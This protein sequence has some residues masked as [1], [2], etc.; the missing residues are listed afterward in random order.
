MLL[1]VGNW[2]AFVLRGLLA[3]AFGLLTFFR[4]GISLLALVYMFG[5]YALAE[6]IFNIIAA[7][8]RTG[9]EQQPW[10]ALLLEGVLSMIA[11]L[12]AFFIPGITAMALLWLIAAWAIATGAMEIA[13]AI[14]LRRQI[15][16][17][18]VLA[19]SGV[20]SILFGA[21]LFAFPGAGALTVV[22]WIGAYAV[23]FG[24]LLIAL[25]IRLRQW[26][27]STF[28]HVAPGFPPRVAPGH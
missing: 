8:R 1:L 3:I 12:L 16:G 20:L 24:I 2:W 19:V 28:Q 22:L 11:G 6:G 7:F 13:A 14:R 5:F 15:K 21:L 26:A 27:R 17:E 18:W 10:W 4:P 23:V 25:G 9:P